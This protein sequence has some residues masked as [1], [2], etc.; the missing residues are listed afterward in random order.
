MDAREKKCLIIF[1][2]HIATTQLFSH[3][4]PREK[5]FLKCV[6]ISFQY[7]STWKICLI[8]YEMRIAA[9]ELVSHTDPRGKT[10][11]ILFEMRNATTY[12]FSYTD[13]HGKMVFSSI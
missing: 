5:T 1:E 8:I 12:L 10:C 2:M 7:R 4:D 6:Y 9:T 11:L 13:P 3:T